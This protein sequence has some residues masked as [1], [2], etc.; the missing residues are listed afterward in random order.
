MREHNYSRAMMSIRW[1]EPKRHA[2]WDKRTIG[3]RGLLPD[4]GDPDSFPEILRRIKTLDPVK[5]IE[6]YDR[7]IEISKSEKS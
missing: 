2:S 3:V 1:R 4:I 5:E 7:R 6:D